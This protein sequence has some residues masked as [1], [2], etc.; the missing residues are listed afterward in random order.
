MR[1]AS[2]WCWMRSSPTTLTRSWCRFRNTRFTGLISHV[3]C[4]SCLICHVSLFHVFLSLV[5]WC[6]FRNTRFAGLFHEYE[7]SIPHCQTYRYVYIYVYIYIYIYTYINICV[8]IHIYIYICIFIYICIYMYIYI[9][10]CM[11]IHMNMYKCQHFTHLTHLPFDLDPRLCCS[12]LTFGDE[13]RNDVQC[14]FY[15]ALV[16]LFDGQLVGYQ[17]DEESGW[18]LDI[19]LLQKVGMYI[20]IYTRVIY[21]YMNKCV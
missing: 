5:S 1:R 13:H 21:K 11:Y 14:S 20:Y 18:S 4:L 16:R 2:K 7:K 12:N 6:R 9:Y 8:Y 3:W 17:M 15:S 10:E 19:K